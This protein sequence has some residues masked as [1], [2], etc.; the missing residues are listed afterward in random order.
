MRRAEHAL[1]LLR[2]LEGMGI[3]Y[4]D[5]SPKNISLPE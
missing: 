5:V 1:R 4:I 2:T 3:Y